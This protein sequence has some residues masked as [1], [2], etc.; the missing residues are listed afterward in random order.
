ME[1]TREDVL[2]CAELVRLQLREDEIPALQR[3][4]TRILEHARSLD[5]VDLSEVPPFELDLPLRRRA[6]EPTPTFTQEEA[7]A[8]SPAQEKGHFSVPKMM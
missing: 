4:M 1:V 2:R 8:Q 3:D 5:R 7:L 6:D